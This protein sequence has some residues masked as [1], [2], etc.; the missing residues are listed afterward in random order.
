MDVLLSKTAIA[1]D[2]N[3]P[4]GKDIVYRASPPTLR[5]HMPVESAGMSL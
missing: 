4:S 5:P 2:R 3:K 1:F